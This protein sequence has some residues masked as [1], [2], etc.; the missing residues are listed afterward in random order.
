MLVAL[1]LLQSPR[2]DVATRTWTKPSC[3][4]LSA[5]GEMVAMVIVCTYT[6]LTICVL[7]GYNKE[8]VSVDMKMQVANQK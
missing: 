6:V 7:L 8:S 1:R 3:S 4:Y 5:E 2:G